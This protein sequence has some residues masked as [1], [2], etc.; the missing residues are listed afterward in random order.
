MRLGL[1]LSGGGTRAVAFHAGVLLRLARCDVLEQVSALST[2]SGGSLTMAL[3]M[4]QAEMTWPSSR[5]FR[6]ETFAKVRGIVGALDLFSMRLIARSPRTWF[7]LGQRAHVLAGSL[8]TRWGIGATLA[9]LPISPKWSINATSLTNGKNWRFARN[10]MGDWKF[11]RHFAPDVPLADAVAASAAVPY[12]IGALKIDLPRD[13]WYD[14]D[15][16]TEQPRQKREAP[17]Q[18]TVLLWDGGAYEN[19]GLEALYKPD[20][21]L[22]ECDS[23]IVSD[24]SGPLAAFKD[25]VGVAGLLSGNLGSPRLFDIASDQI[26]AL[27]SRMF[28]RDVVAGR[29]EGAII[30]MGNSIRDIDIKCGRSRVPDDQDC[31]QT[32]GDVAAAWRHPTHLRALGEH[33]FDR[34]ARHGFECADA[35]L[36]AYKPA[37]LARSRTWPG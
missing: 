34:I 26:R 2:V 14:I 27:R 25:S 37:I 32:E 8:R 9:D 31:W 29:L 19:L 35:T 16:A 11:G 24:A 28:M 21:R 22:F 7:M 36:T 33:E 18:H 5:R 30:R 17:P 4:A 15:P 10:E 6:D 3:V 12:V 13:G 23:V 20:G 1:A